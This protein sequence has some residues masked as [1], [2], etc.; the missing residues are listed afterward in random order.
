M[1]LLASLAGIVSRGLDDAASGFLEAFDWLRRPR[2][3]RLVERAEG[4]FA[5]QDGAGVTLVPLARFADDAW[6]DAEARSLAPRLAGAN[7]ELCLAATRFVFSEIELPRRAGDFLEGVVRAQIDSL[8]PWKPQDALFGWS[9]PRSLGAE[10][11]SVTVATTP[12]LAA[13]PLAAALEAARV[14][15]F[16]ISAPPPGEAP[17]AP[18]IAVLSRRPGELARRGL[19]RGALAGVL[20]LAVAAAVLSA[21][22]MALIGGDVD[23]RTATL[24]NQIAARRAALQAGHGSAADQAL[25]LLTARRRATPASVLVIEAL[26]R[27]LPDNVYLTQLHIEGDKVQFGGLAADAPALIG[28]IEQSRSFRHA[29]FDAPTTRTPNETGERF[30]IEAQAEPNFTAPP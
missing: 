7:V 29:V 2:A 6:R 22:A 17:G 4:G 5:L 15:R 30:H 21:L 10:R 13:S 26:S 23:E 11:I 27:T 1:S 25:A 8:T 14:D 18:R 24:E 16:R 9:A 12:R 19:W 3:L 20:A 28:L